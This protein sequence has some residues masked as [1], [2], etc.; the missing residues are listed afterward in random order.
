MRIGTQLQERLGQIDG[1]LLMIAPG[2]GIEMHREDLPDWLV[3]GEP[4]APEL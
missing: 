2:R 4:Q 3:K 1:I